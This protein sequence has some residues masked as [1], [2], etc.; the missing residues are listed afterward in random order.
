MADLPLLLEPAYLEQIRERAKNPA[1]RGRWR[2]KYRDIHALLSHI[3]ALD[4]RLAE[5]ERLAKER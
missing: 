3:R 5:I 2:T 1:C 4:A